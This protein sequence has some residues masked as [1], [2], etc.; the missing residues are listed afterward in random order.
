MSAAHGFIRGA[1]SRAQGVA[2]SLGC[3]LHGQ[4]EPVRA[5]SIPPPPASDSI[6]H[7]LPQAQNMTVATTLA[8]AHRQAAVSALAWCACSAAW[9]VG[10]AGG[11][12]GGSAGLAMRLCAAPGVAGAGS[13]VVRMVAPS[14]KE[15]LSALP[16]SRARAPPACLFASLQVCLKSVASWKTPPGKHPRWCPRTA[17]TPNPSHP[18]PTQPQP[19]GLMPCRRLPTRP[20]PPPHP[21]GTRAEVP[22][23]PAPPRSCA[24]PQA[25][26]RG[27]LWCGTSTRGR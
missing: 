17:F 26:R 23:S 9:R 6:V 21:A 7:E 8:G 27:A 18:N 14:R 16:A 10:Y 11:L 19:Q 13:W 22:A 4:P 24:W 25:T 12:P 2:G 1:P 20:R 3:W 15:L 5:G